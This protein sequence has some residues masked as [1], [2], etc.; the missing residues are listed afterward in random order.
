[1]R[2]KVIFIIA[3]LLTM[4]LLPI[5][6]TRCSVKNPSVTAFSTSD[7]I[8]ATQPSEIQMQPKENKSELGEAELCGLVA[9]N[10]DESYSQETLKALAVI[11]YT[12]YKANSESYDLT[13]KEV[14]IKESDADSS[15]KENYDKIKAAVSSVYKKTLC[16]NGKAF[17]IPFCSFTN[18]KTYETSDYPYLTAVA[19]PWD[20]Y[21]G[22][23]ESSEYYGVSLYG[24]NF[25]CSQG[26]TYEEALL[27]YLP[28]FEIR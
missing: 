14:C 23:A 24:L 6:I 2:I 10:Y 26:C 7:E 25:I 20:C 5:F 13:D 15:L 3:F 28:D 22:N 4:A 16:T 8:A 9:S 27:W 19:S 12:N 18:G 1:M 17:F 11:L 21:A